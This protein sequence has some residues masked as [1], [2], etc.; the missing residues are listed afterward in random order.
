MFEQEEELSTHLSHLRVGVRKSA[1]YACFTYLLDG[2]DELN[3]LRRTTIFSAQ[4][5]CLFQK[6]KILK[7]EFLRRIF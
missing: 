4:K 1:E 5:K 7:R 2:Y 6:L 3:F